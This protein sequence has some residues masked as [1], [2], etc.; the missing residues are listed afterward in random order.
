MGAS[1]DKL[2]KSFSLV[3]ESIYEVTD[4]FPMIKSDDLDSAIIKSTIEY[5]I[6][7]SQIKDFLI[8]DKSLGQ[9]I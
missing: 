2:I 8:Q 9:L 4:K 3:S 7:V 6:D 5:A 1:E